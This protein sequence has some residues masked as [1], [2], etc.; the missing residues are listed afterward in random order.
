MVHKQ[1]LYRRLHLPLF[2]VLAVAIVLSLKA[3]IP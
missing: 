1:D 3:G 2:V